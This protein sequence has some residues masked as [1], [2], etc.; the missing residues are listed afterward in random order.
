MF[1]MKEKQMISEKIE[2]LV[3]SLN[4]P[5]MPKE[6][7]VFHLHVDGKESWSWADI[8]PNW[9]F[10]DKNKPGINPFNEIARDIIK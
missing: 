6:K 5:E 1:S 3:L 9:T 10:D 2:E 4:H 7:P 8:K